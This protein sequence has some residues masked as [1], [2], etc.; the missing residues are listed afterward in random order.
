MISSLQEVTVQ[1][2]LITNAVRTL[3][4]YAYGRSTWSTNE[5][6]RFPAAMAWQCANSNSYYENV[7]STK[8]EIYE[9]AFSGTNSGITSI[10]GY[11]PSLSELFD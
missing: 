3:A 2:L 6:V 11:N 8:P 7:L 1:L 10:V 4:V 9:Q 5:L